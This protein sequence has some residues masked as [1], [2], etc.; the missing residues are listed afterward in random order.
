MQC[1]EVPAQSGVVR[2]GM[3][4]HAPKLPAA[5]VIRHATPAH[6]PAR[7]YAAYCMH[8]PSPACRRSPPHLARARSVPTHPMQTAT[9][10]ASYYTHVL[11]NRLRSR[12]L[13][14]ARAPWSAQKAAA[15][16]ST[17]TSFMVTCYGLRT[18]RAMHGAPWPQ[19]LCQSSSRSSSP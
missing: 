14:S 6:A 11:P 16:R 19:T 5:C 12:L 7:Q 10:E 8:M 4:C 15:G 9:A 2:Q 13:S 18:A 17:T 1:S 3:R